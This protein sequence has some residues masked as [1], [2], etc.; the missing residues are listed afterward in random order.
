MNGNNF[1]K[2]GK[3]QSKKSFTFIW[4]LTNNVCLDIS[5]EEEITIHIR[6][7]WHHV[8]L[9]GLQTRFC[10][11]LHFRHQWVLQSCCSFSLEILW[12]HFALQFKMR[13]SEDLT[14]SSYSCTQVWVLMKYFGDV[15]KAGAILGYPQC[16]P[17]RVNI[18]FD[19]I[20]GEINLSTAEKKPLVACF[21]FNQKLCEHSNEVNSLLLN[22]TVIFFDWSSP[23]DN[24]VEWIFRGPYCKTH[25]VKSASSI[26]IDYY[27]YYL[28]THH[29]NIKLTMKKDEDKKIYRS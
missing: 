18:D 12:Q 17:R 28:N 11:R 9:S 15:S 13:I 2:D 21:C 3:L 29:S 1:V 22:P 4:L 14:S 10:Q 8:L 16:E 5:N 19:Q 27:Y 26:K 6:K 25:I 20:K 7:L 24:E 23:F